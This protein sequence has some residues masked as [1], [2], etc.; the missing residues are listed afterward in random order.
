MYLRTDHIKGLTFE[1]RHLPYYINEVEMMLL[2]IYR[3]NKV[4]AHMD[5]N[6]TKVAFLFCF[7]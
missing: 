7:F 3:V 1:K 5:C 2:E 4:N 6:N